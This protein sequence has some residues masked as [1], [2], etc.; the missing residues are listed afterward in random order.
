MFDYNE[1]IKT[2]LNDLL[3]NKVFIDELK[4]KYKNNTQ[5]L[6]TALMEVCEEIV[7]EMNPYEN[8][9]ISPE[10]F[11]NNPYYCGYNHETGTGVVETMHDKLREDF[12]KMHDPKNKITE[13]ILTGSI[14]WGKSFF[15]SL[16]LIWQVYILSK[17]KSPQ[18]YFDLAPQS[19]ISIMIIS[20]T[21]EQ[22]KKNVFFNVKEMIKQIPYFQKEFKYDEKK[23]TQSLLFPKNIEL[24]N[25]NSSEASAIGLNIYSACIDEANF[26]KVVKHSKRGRRYGEVYDQAKVL[27]DSLLRRQDSRFLKKGK[28]PGILYL[29]SSKL[30]P[31]DFIEKRIKYARERESITGKSTSYIMDYSRWSVARNQYS[32]EEF[33]VEVDLINKKTRILEGNETDVQ[34]NI[35]NIP[36]DF[37]E[38]FQMDLDGSLRDIAG[39]AMYST[40]PFLTL[41][42]K[43]NEAFDP[44]MEKHFTVDEATLSDKI[45]IS[46]LEYI[47]GKPKNPDKLRV[48]SVDLGIKKDAS[49]FAM[50]YLDSFHRVEREY[51]DSETGEV[52]KTSEIVPRIIVEF[53]LRIVPELEKGEV[54]IADIRQ[55]IFKLRDRGWKIMRFTADGF[56]STDTFQILQKKGISGKYVSVDRTPEPYEVLRQAIYEGRI[57]IVEHPQL[58]DE[59]YC[60]E[61]S[62]ETGKVDHPPL[63]S[64]D[65]ADAVCQLTYSLMTE[66]PK[67][68]MDLLPM[69]TIGSQE[70]IEQESEEDLEKRF[71]EWANE[72]K[73]IRVDRSYDS[74]L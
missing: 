27:Y 43:I 20:L 62:F 39:I 12:I 23:D 14:G 15:L 46:Q 63:G 25:G 38:K 37:F 67:T 18:K 55:L 64:K 73:L 7:E 47:L 22:S 51:V 13:A 33:K 70:D 6:Q 2:V 1:K 50:G 10:E 66:A 30:F 53:V 54:Q 5:L 49:G 21:E 69:A 72:S 40:Q 4:T 74:E 26:F 34:G 31:N 36:K 52:K 61:K 42:N 16:G 57:K 44:D 32:K 65:I 11:L 59:L 35:I 19:K 48:V 28:A 8:D 60:L 41:R 24:F 45:E 29:A 68:G 58:R 71:T 56:Q 3:S 9:I 17:L